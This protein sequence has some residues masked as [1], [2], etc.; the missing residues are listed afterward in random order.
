MQNS[1]L[2]IRREGDRLARAVCES[3][4]TTTPKS[5]LVFTVAPN[6][7]IYC[8]AHWLALVRPANLGKMKIGL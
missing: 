6:L 7:L 3:R 8:H 2:A 5:H 1:L 4:E